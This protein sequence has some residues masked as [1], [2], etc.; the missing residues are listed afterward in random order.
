MS[1]SE[2]EV[3]VLG[4]VKNSLLPWTDGLTLAR[5]L[6]EAEYEKQTAPIA[7][8]IFRNNQPLHIDPQLVL[9]GADYP[10]YPGD[11]VFIQDQAY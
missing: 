8:T 1:T 11:T 6:V 2:P 3:R 10:L 5:A 7:I 4:S 9:Q